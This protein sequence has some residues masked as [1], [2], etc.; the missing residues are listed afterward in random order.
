MSTTKSYAKNSVSKSYCGTWNNY[1]ESELIEFKEW[2]EQECTYGIIAQEVC[3]KTGTAHLQWCVTTKKAMR[4]EA[5]KKI[6]PKCHIEVP[7]H[8]AKSRNYCKKDGNFWEHDITE[9][10]RRTDIEMAIDTL[11]KDGMKTCAENHSDVFVKYNKGIK[12]LLCIIS[13]PKE[14]PEILIILD[15]RGEFWENEAK[16]L[17]DYYIVPPAKNGNL[18]FDAYCGQNI[19]IFEDFEG[20][21]DQKYLLQTIGGRCPLVPT[22]GGQV[23][24]NWSLVIFTSILE[25]YSWWERFDFI[26]WKRLKPEIKKL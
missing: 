5:F 9:Q 26:R 1:S 2:T 15:I 10:G 14:V 4:F 21:I 12:E 13:E 25:P 23:P 7:L 16:D 17:K 6:F 11:K 3:P 19:I 18:W 8:L 20:E 22:K 24:K